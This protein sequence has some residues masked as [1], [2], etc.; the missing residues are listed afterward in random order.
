MTELANVFA[1]V[2]ATLVASAAV[3]GIVLLVIRA[4]Q[5]S[6]LEKQA[7]KNGEQV[8]K[9]MVEIDDALQEICQRMSTSNQAVRDNQD[10]LRRMIQAVSHLVLDVERRLDSSIKANREWFA[11][12]FGAK[13]T[14]VNF[15]HDAT[16]TQI[17]EGNRQQ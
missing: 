9:A 7:A 6:R 2:L 1:G 13:G 10:D 5:S 4:V 17:G 11:M 16:G 15:N 14:H 3:A 12:Q 8:A